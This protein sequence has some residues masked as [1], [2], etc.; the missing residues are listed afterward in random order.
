[1]LHSSTHHP[2]CEAATRIGN[3]KPLSKNCANRIPESIDNRHAIQIDLEGLVAERHWSEARRYWEKQRYREEI[4]LPATEVSRADIESLKSY[5]TQGGSDA[6]AE[7][8]RVIQH[9]MAVARARVYPQT[10][11]L[12]WI[13]TYLGLFNS[14]FILVAPLALFFATRWWWA[15]AAIAFWY[16]VLNWIQTTVN[17]ELGARLLATDQQSAGPFKS[18]GDDEGGEGSPRQ[19]PTDS[20]MPTQE[21]SDVGDDDAVNNAIS[22]CFN[23]H[24][25]IVSALVGN[26]KLRQLPIPSQLLAVGET[27]CCFLHF[28]DRTLYESAPQNRNQRMDRLVIASINA[29]ADLLERKCGAN[30]DQANGAADELITG[31]YNERGNEYAVIRDRWFEKVLLRY[32]SHLIQ[33]LHE[34]QAEESGMNPDYSLRLMVE[35]ERLFALSFGGLMKVVPALFKPAPTQ[36][37]VSKESNTYAVYARNNSDEE[38][39]LRRSYDMPLVACAMAR[40]IVRGGHKNGCSEAEAMVMKYDMPFM[41]ERGSNLRPG[42]E[43]LAPDAAKDSF[44]LTS[45]PDSEMGEHGWFLRE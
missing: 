29:F 31:M 42:L 1:M 16:F 22:Y 17:I 27:V 44:Y 38:W 13:R 34:E 26:E 33:A 7:M 35:A 43:T 45:D 11:R 36:E 24:N 30:R 5:I 8:M 32:A 20:T 41:D 2:S 4:S 25:E 12:Q 19:G 14:I 23:K 37:R 15:V 40:L 18:N 3:R 39:R 10:R 28:I 9:P 6:Y 21:N